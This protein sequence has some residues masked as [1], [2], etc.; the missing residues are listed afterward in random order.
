MWF[1]LF[2][3]LLTLVGWSALLWLVIP[4]DIFDY[5]LPTIVAM[6]LTPPMILVGL[7]LLIQYFRKKR[8]SAQEE[9]IADNLQEIR[10]TEKSKQKKAFE[11]AM[12]LRRAMIECR[13]AAIADVRYLGDVSEQ[14]L[15][16]EQTVTR[17][18]TPQENQSS[19]KWPLHSLIQTLGELFT[20]CP[21]A[22][23]LPI[24]VNG[25]AHMSSD[26]L[27]TLMQEARTQALEQQ[28]LKTLD[29]VPPELVT[30]SA[31]G[32]HIHTTLFQLFADNPSWPGVITV[33]FDTPWSAPDDPPSANWDFNTEV[34]ET[35]KWI[36]KPG[37]AITVLLL[38]TENLSTVLTKINALGDQAL[39]DNMTPYWEREHIPIGMAGFLS[40]IPKAWRDSLA[41]TPPVAAIHRATSVAISTVSSSPVT[42]N[43]AAKVPLAERVKLLSN[44]IA[45]AAI[46]A[47][48]IEPLFVFEEQSEQPIEPAQPIHSCGW[49][50]HNAGHISYSGERMALLGS[51]MWDQ[52]IDLNPINQATNVVMTHGDC[53]EAARWLWLAL[54]LQRVAALSTP[55]LCVEFEQVNLSVYFLQAMIAD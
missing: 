19:N 16:T 30:L 1:I 21:A 33:A 28:G 2:L 36:G 46:D 20:Q 44:A 9:A 47:R 38:T 51:A 8:I 55:V 35:E 7:W 15:D 11:D 17:I 18:F 26:D 42:A 12:Q 41:T 45:T 24:A 5:A 32:N 25:P 31:R 49:L 39:T 40:K 34:S 48:L 3:F 4:I 29:K 22:T 37:R 53:G 6:H 43:T 54:G 50:I 52:S 23:C 10:E 27:I 13:W 14:C